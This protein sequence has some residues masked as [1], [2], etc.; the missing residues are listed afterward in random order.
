M[1]SPIAIQAILGIP[2]EATECEK[3]NLTE[4]QFNPASFATIS[5]LLYLHCSFPREK[6]FQNTVLRIYRRRRILSVRY[7]LQLPRFQ[8]ADPKVPGACT[9]LL[10]DA[11]WIAAQRGLAALPRGKEV[12]KW[13]GEITF[14]KSF[15][16]TTLGKEILAEATS[17]LTEVYR[18]THTILK[19]VTDYSAQQSG[20]VSHGNGI[21]RP[22]Q[23]AA[24]LVVGPTAA[25][26]TPPAATPSN[27]CTHSTVRQAQAN[28]S[29]MR[30]K[31]RDKRRARINGWFEILYRFRQIPRL[32]KIEDLDSD[33]YMMVR[34]N[35]KNST[36]PL[37][38]FEGPF[39]AYLMVADRWKDMRLHREPREYDIII[40]VCIYENDPEIRPVTILMIDEAKNSHL[41]Y[42]GANVQARDKYPLAQLPLKGIV[43]PSFRV[44]AAQ[45]K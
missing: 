21:S 31:P 2:T 36:L 4:A 6:D 19:V 18:A 24:H 20:I 27:E 34:G 10:F 22:N 15:P 28:P 40:M 26:V 32:D 41:I 5:D 3:A 23:D 11:V 38:E 43:M 16:H 1:N 37:P 14:C 45:P 44:G 17:V 9:R 29:R 8:G 35:T 39:Q 12:L 33:D 7:F 13:K 25:E 42:P 30:Q